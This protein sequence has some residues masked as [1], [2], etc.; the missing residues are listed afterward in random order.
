MGTSE[1]IEYTEYGIADR[2]EDKILINRV[3]LK[4]R[5]LHEFLLGHERG[6]NDPGKNL[7]KDFKHDTNYNKQNQRMLFKVFLFC[8][9]YPKTWTQLLPVRYH[10]GDIYFD[11]MNL[12][13][14][15]AAGII[16]AIFFGLTLLVFK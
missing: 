6:H 15:I 13:L 2:M 12:V 3:F 16:F 1:L 14:W 8:L 7:I 4:N 11:L 10:K 5:V 9:K